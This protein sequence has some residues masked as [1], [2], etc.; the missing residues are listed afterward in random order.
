MNTK[1]LKIFIGKLVADYRGSP[2]K[3]PVPVIDWASVVEMRV[4]NES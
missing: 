1:N 4:Q 3:L 2:L